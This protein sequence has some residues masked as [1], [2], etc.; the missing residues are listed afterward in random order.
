[1]NTQEVAQDLVSLCRKGQFGEAGEKYW[2]ENVL[3]VEPMG[4]NA[5]SR[6]KQAA[7]QKGEWWSQH[8]D[9]HD[10]KVEGP[11]VN[12][13]EF[14]VRFT[15][16]VT[17]KDNGQRMKMDEVALYRLEGGKIAEERFFLSA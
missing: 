7:R 14:T 5:E 13:D 10:V 9:V 8:H 4:D 6:G 1:M 11:Y 17:N 16:D 3:S 12:G 15:M 2:S